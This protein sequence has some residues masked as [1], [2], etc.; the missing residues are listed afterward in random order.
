MPSTRLPVPVRELLDERL[1]ESDVKRAWNSLEAKR[2]R[3]PRSKRPWVW[4]LLFAPGVLGAVLTFLWMRAPA[5]GVL[6]L[7]DGSDVP[8]HLETRAPSLPLDDGSELTLRAGTRLDL[9]ESTP[10]IFSLALRR[11]ATVFEVH[12]GGPRLWKVECGPVT[13]EVVGTHF[14][15]VRDE[16]HVQVS[17]DRGAVL[18]SGEP[19]PDRVVRLGPQQSIVVPLPIAAEKVPNPP[20]ERPPATDH[21]PAP[22]PDSKDPSRP[23]QLALDPP[24]ARRAAAEGSAE[25]VA[26]S[27]DPLAAPSASETVDRAAPSASETV[28]RAAPSVDTLLA[29]ADDARLAGR[30]REAAAILEHVV[31]E[32]AGDR[33]A[34]LAEFSL[35]RLY[36]DSLDDP[37][38]AAIHFSRAL[39]HGLSDALAED[40]YARLVEAYARAGDARAARDIADRYLARYP[41]GRRLDAVNRWTAAPS[42]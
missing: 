28:D 36:L 12:P 27:V 32:R 35:G 18:V 13:V 15:I 37:A 29:Q 1:A 16:K 34:S 14:T 21:G 9:L 26:P 38:R 42:P 31:T 30:Y 33:R 39:L 40:A 10:R 41:H 5:P 22:A 8:Q 25:A 20:E 2:A 19:V 4:T 24:R 3:A 17:V 6:H 11:G 23:D 7:A